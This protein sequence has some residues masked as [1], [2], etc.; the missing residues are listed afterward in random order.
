MNENI[1]HREAFEY[2]YSLGD[3]R[4]LKMV[5]ERFNCTLR[6]AELWSAT[7]KWQNKIHE[8]DKAIADELQKKLVKSAV[9]DKV[10]Y[11]KMII[12][13]INPV[14]K[15]MQ[16]QA[17]MS[18]EAKAQY[19][20]NNPDTVVVKVASVTDLERL[21]KLDML[22]VGEDTERVGVHNSIK[23]LVEAFSKESENEQKEIVE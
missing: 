1:K 19:L 3:A 8:R 18:A 10:K 4:T 21:V 6:T 11:H 13:L 7:F 14:L 16:Y 23:S 9:D 20:M 15:G 5:S 12:S 22:L 2:Y 17:L